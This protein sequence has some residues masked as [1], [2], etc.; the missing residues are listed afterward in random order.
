MLK[1]AG[2][3]IVCAAA[4]FIFFDYRRASMKRISEL[5]EFSRFLSFLS[6][7]ISC[8]LRPIQECTKAFSSDIFSSVGFLN[9]G[10]EIAESFNTACP[11]L[12]ITEEEKALL[13]SFFCNMGKGYMEKELENIRRAESA[14]EERLKAAE[15]ESEKNIKIAAVLTASFALGVIILFL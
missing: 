10:E 5:R 4:L 6:S 13:A 15:S 2:F 11:L 9:E 12:S 14:L 3:S 7:E 8:Y 1:Y